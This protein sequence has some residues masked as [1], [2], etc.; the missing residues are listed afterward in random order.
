MVGSAHLIYNEQTEN[1]N[2]GNAD[3]DTNSFHISINRLQDQEQPRHKN[4]LISFKNKPNFLPAGRF[5]VIR[6]RKLLNPAA[7]KQL[8]KKPVSAFIRNVGYYIRNSAC[9]PMYVVSKMRK[10]RSGTTGIG[11]DP[12]SD[13]L[14]VAQ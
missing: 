7:A 5:Y 8:A 1:L 14:A 12:D 10:S 3:N 6:P 2:G 4:S 11:V 13:T 9:V